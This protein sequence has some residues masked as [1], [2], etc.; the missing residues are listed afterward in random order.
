RSPPGERPVPSRAMRAAT[1]GAETRRFGRHAGLLSAGVAASGLLT[2]AFFSLAGHNL[3]AHDYGEITVLWSV[4]FVT[5][6]IAHRPVELLLSR[7]L[8]GRR[9][10]GSEIGSAL[11]I[12][13]AIQLAVSAALAA[14]ALALREA[15]QDG[16]LS[17]SETLYWVLV[18]AVVAFGPSF[19]A[20]GYLAG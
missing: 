11:R 7:T 15:L 18:V 2:Y 10:L 16:L 13:A 20:R 8:A 12:G 6:S 4:V 3:S 9:A 1:P 19:Y 17:G 14:A 5:I